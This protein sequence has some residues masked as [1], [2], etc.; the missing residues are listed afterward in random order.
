MVI[1]HYKLHL[2]YYT[3]FFFQLYHFPVFHILTILQGTTSSTE[4]ALV[5]LS[6]RDHRER[7]HNSLVS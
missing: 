3:L 6:F 2:V 5:I 7:M 4:S 1:V